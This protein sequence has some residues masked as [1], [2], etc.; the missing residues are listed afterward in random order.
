MIALLLAFSL[1]LSPAPIRVE[2]V[3]LNHVY[4]ANCE[5]SFDQLILR[6]WQRLTAGDGH[7]VTDWQ[8][9]TEENRL[10]IRPLDDLTLI[11]W[12]H[13]GEDYAILTLRVRETWTQFDPEVLDRKKLKPDDRRS[14]L[15]ETK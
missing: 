3:E 5:H 15:K 1:S 13:E 6:R 4:D 10:V 12:N 9:I 11:T 7:Y 8:T 14:Y 2:R